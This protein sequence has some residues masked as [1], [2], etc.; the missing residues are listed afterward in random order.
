M[1]ARTAFARWDGSLREGAGTV[2]L[3][4]GAFEGRY[5]FASRFEDGPGTNPEELI[6]A[7]HAGCFSMALTAGLERAG[8][9]PALVETTAT[10]HVERGEDGFRI[11]RIELDC[12][13]A[14]PGIDDDE[15]QAQATAA[16]EGCPVSK[17]L[18]GTEIT[19]TARLSG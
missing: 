8:Y 11:P 3:G 2:R 15:F 7:A 9:R 5:S 19:L 17:A 10:V 13:A 16:K 6:G 12:T 14:V 1:P 18:A 4:S